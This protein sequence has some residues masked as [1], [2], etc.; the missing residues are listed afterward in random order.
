MHPIFSR[1]RH[2]LERTKEEAEV[3]RESQDL[4]R[5]LPPGR[6]ADWSHRANA[7][8]GIVSVYSGLETILKTVADEI[9]HYA[10]AGADWHAK[11]LEAMAL[12]IEGIRPAVLSP[13][14]YALLN[15][16]RKFRHVVRSNYGMD[17]NDRGVTENRE[18]LHAVLPAFERDLA[19]FERAMMAS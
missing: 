12:P 5:V 13:G 18:R 8:F 17:L 9:D 15:E 6:A 11:L 19:A 7:A 4:L 16:L 2:R 14:T 1:L 10:P 3:F